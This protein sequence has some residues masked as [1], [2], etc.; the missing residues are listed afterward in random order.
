MMNL[1]ISHK[2]YTAWALIIVLMAQL[3]APYQSF[4]LTGGPSQP[5]VQSFEPIGTSEMVDMATGGLIILQHPAARSR[6]LSYQY[7]IPC[8]ITPDMEAKA[9]GRTGLEH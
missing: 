7:C 5:E 6:G 8:G 2:R 1:S 4:A 9:L 3:F